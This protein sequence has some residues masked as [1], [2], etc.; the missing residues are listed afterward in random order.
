MGG[1][2]EGTQYCVCVKHPTR[3]LTTGVEVCCSGNGARANAVYGWFGRG[4]SAVGERSGKMG[5]DKKLTN[6]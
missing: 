3:P 2:G 5:K 1:G 6:R 4:A